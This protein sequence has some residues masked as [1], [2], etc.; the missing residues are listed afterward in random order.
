MFKLVVTKNRIYMISSLALAAE[1]EI[2]KGAIG[3]KREKMVHKCTEIL[4]TLTYFGA[5]WAFFLIFF[6]NGGLYSRAK[7]GIQRGPLKSL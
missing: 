4:T 2:K 3:V 5:K 7:A 6:D 1:D